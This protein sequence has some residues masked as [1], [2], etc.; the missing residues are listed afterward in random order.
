MGFEKYAKVPSHEEI[1][2]EDALASAQ[3]N[4]ELEDEFD[5]ES[6]VD[7]DSSSE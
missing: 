4:I 6:N 1:S 2:K 5:Q 7:E 3:K